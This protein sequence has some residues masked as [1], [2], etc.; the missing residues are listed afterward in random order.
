MRRHRPAVASPPASSGPSGEPSGE[1]ASA[2]PPEPTGKLVFS[3]V[4]NG[5]ADIYVWEA[6]DARP[7]KL[8][9]GAGNE[10]DPAWSPDG[11]KVVF[12]LNVGGFN[13][14][15]GT[16]DEG[17]RVIKADGTKAKVFDL[18]HH[19]V[20]RNPAWSPDGQTVVWASTRDHAD[21][22][23]L[24]IY[25]RP[26]EATTTETPL[27]DDPADDWDPAF[28]ADGKTDRLRVQARRPGDAVHDDPGGQEAAAARSRHGGLRRPHLLARRRPAGVH[29]EGQRRRPEAAVRRGQGRFGLAAARIV[30]RRR[31][32][33]DVVAG[34]EADR[35][36]QRRHRRDRHRRRRDA[37]T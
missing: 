30:H 32:R 34:R 7:H 2:P 20:D 16:P 29:D 36:G 14:L 5:N 27:A 33:P 37:A 23:N 1:P 12:A 13:P 24:D 31:Q 35:G 18:T 10:F 15:G 22:K 4:K 19:D 3:A 8:F 26:Y 21:N 9:G 11:S 28:S 25:S 17:L 6:G